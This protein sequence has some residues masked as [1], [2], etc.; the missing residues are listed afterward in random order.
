MSRNDK[1]TSKAVRRKKIVRIIQAI[2]VLIIVLAMI[3]AVVF[4]SFAK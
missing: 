1:K 4:A 3:I 2:I